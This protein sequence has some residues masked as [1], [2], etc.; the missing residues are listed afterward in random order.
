[1]IMLSSYVHLDSL[2]EESESIQIDDVNGFDNSI[3]L[4]F[5]ERL[6]EDGLTEQDIDVVGDRVFSRWR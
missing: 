1:M 2:R 6:K 3:V 5:L 4:P